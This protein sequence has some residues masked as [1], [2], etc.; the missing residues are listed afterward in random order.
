MGLLRMCEKVDYC[1]VRIDKCLKVFID[2][3]NI[4]LHGNVE[5]IASCCGHGKYPMSIVVKVRRNKY[6]LSIYDL[7]SGK[8]IPRT[9][10]IYRR[11]D[12]GYYFIPEAIKNG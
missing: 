3:L 8:E 9:R 4:V 6:R 11:D 12:G 10:N 1:N 2:N 7:V 5:T